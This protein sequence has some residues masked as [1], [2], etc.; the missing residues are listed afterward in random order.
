[1]DSNERWN[2][3]SWE[4]GSFDAPQQLTDKCTVGEIYYNDKNKL[5]Y[6]IKKEGT[7]ATNGW[8]F[9]RAKA[10]NAHWIYTGDNRGT[11]HSPKTWCEYGK[12]G[13]V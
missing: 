5:F 4:M 7:P 3:I 2:L 13:A 10:D 8:F 1:G 9:P 11:L 6:A 12:Q